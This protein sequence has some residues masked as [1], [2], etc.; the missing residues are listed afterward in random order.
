MKNFFLSE[1]LLFLKGAVVFAIGSL[2]HQLSYLALAMVIDLIFGIQV[3]LKER[4]FKAMTLVKKFGVKAVIYT[5]WIAMFHAFDMVA[6]FPDTARWSLI[7]ILVGLEIMS[8][9]KNTSKL[10]YGSLADTLER[11]YL[12]LA[13]QK[14]GTNDVE[15][16][17]KMPKARK[18]RPPATPT[19]GSDTL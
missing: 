1:P 16:P 5:L 4:N 18:K 19:D 3:A 14:G 12:S 17:K 10:G 15:E 13:K 6:G 7:L 11:L 8:A 2:N 9:I